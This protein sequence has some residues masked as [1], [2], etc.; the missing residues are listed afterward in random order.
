MEL[1][2]SQIASIRA[3]RRHG[4]SGMHYLLARIR[5]ELEARW[6]AVE[7]ARG[8]YGGAQRR[9]RVL[10]L[11]FDRS[12][13]RLGDGVAV[14]RVCALESPAA[15]RKL[16]EAPQAG[17]FDGVVICLQAAWL[18]W[19]AWPAEML[20][21]LRPGGRLLFCTFGPDTLQQL[22][23][24]WRQADRRPHVHPFID[25]HL[26]GDQLLHCGF[27][28]PIVDADWVTVHYPQDAALY[29]D[30]RAE[31]FT[32][33]LAARRKTLTGKARF[34]RYQEAL[35]ELREPGRPLAVTFEL[36]YGVAGAPP[37]TEA[38]IQVAPPRLPA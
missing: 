25:M 29:A 23:Q 34:R 4:P 28:D 27:T 5:R 3:R 1:E 26:V 24:A 11:D 7:A 12:D 21:V 33:I 8:G 6:A 38:R 36:V 17:G 31:G 10:L 32:N 20:R 9:R 16:F 37:A 35:D 19:P 30:L 2:L 22:R 14:R 13:L 15:A 18:Q